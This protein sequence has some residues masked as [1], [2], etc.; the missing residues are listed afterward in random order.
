M[1]ALDYYYTDAV[2]TAESPEEA[3]ALLEQLYQTSLKNQNP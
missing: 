3:Q 2:C 1:S